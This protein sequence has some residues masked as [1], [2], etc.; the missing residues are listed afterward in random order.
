[1]FVFDVV[2]IVVFLFSLLPLVIVF[3][4]IPLCQNHVRKL[5]LISSLNLFKALI[6]LCSYANTVLAYHFFL[7]PQCY[8][9]AFMG[10]S[11]IPAK[12]Y[13]YRR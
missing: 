9:D 2:V 7:P 3:S 10:N 6:P 13:C 12:E 1:M 5:L 8:P 11:H 4:L